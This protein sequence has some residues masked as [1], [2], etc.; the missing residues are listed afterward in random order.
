MSVE[1]A[2]QANGGLR[3]RAA[4]AAVERTLQSSPTRDAAASGSSSSPAAGPTAGT[5]LRRVVV[6][7]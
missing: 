1:T 2:L 7:V 3:E 4:A 5:D 6:F